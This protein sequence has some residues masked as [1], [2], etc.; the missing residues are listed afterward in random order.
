[1]TTAFATLC[2]RLSL[3]GG[4][5]ITNGIAGRRM[6]HE[7]FGL[8]ALLLSLNLLANGLDLGFKFTMGNR[9]TALGSRG[10]D[11]E[12]ERRETFVAILYL[13]AALSVTLILAALLICPRI[14][15]AHWLNVADPTLAAQ[16]QAMMPVVVAL[17]LGTLPLS[18]S[19]SVFFAYHEIKLASAM[20]AATTFLQTALFILGAYTLHFLPLV[21]FYYIANVVIL[22]AATLY[23]FA[24]RGWRFSLPRTAWAVDLIRSL[25]PVSFHAFL[26]G[27]PAIITMVLGPFISSYVSGIAAAGEFTVIQ[28]LF[29]FLITAHLSILS[30]FSP[31]FTLEAQLGE[32]DKVRH[33]L[34]LCVLKI[35]PVSFAVA[36]LV[37]WWMHPVLSRL[38]VGRTMTNYH[39]AGLLLA[40]ACLMGF[41]NTYSLFLNSLGLV[42]LQA[43]ISLAM[44][45]PSLLVPAILS[46]FYGSA[47]IALGMALCT[48]PTACILPFYARRAL[49]L[50]VTR[51]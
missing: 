49:R 27:L 25:A 14:S 9:L 38:W 24:Y 16:A 39:L 47:G 41:G 5:M 30:P 36:G 31:K 32:W 48:I 40:W 15:W 42:K 46:R 2:A 50:R 18:M 11:G 28:K 6:S 23:M 21:V 19:G 4:M 34:R 29:S 13:E 10:A 7:Q 1:M 43:A 35:F 44:V 20:V 51:V 12:E 26:L 45:V 22:T 33:R 17:M 3:I 8:W 37:V